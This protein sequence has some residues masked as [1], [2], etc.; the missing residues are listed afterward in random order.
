[1]FTT[2]VQDICHTLINIDTT[3]IPVLSL[4]LPTELSLPTLNRGLLLTS[5][6][7]IL[8]V[9]TPSTTLSQLTD[10]LPLPSIDPALIVI[11]IGLESKS[12]CDPIRLY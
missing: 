4:I 2:T 1:M 8:K 5:V 9:S 3:I 6:K 11:L 10:M 12:T 7:L